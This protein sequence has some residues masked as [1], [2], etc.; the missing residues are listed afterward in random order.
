VTIQ[1][2]FDSYVKAAYGSLAKHEGQ[3]IELRRAFFAGVWAQLCERGSDAD[4][5]RVVECQAF[6]AEVLVGTK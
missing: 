5:L 2:E 3:Y 1:D 6:K 4:R